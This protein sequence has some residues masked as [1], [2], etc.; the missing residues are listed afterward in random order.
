MSEYVIVTDSA[1]DLNQEMADKAG[2]EVL[3]LSFRIRGEALAR[4]KAMSEE[5]GVEF[6][7]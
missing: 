4:V 3:P 1:G 5:R 6:A 2:V 7:D